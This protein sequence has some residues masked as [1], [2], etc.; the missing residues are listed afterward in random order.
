METLITGLA[1]F[2]VSYLLGSISFSWIAMRLLSRGEDVGVI[3]VE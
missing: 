1:V 2:V 3:E